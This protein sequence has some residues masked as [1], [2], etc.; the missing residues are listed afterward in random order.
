MNASDNEITFQSDHELW[1]SEI[2]D[3]ILETY[4]RRFWSE[5]TIVSN[6]PKIGDYYLNLT[7]D[8]S[9]NL[10]PS[11]KEDSAWDGEE[12]SNPES[13]EEISE[14]NN[15]KVH[16]DKNAKIET[17]INVESLVKQYKN[18]YLLANMV[19][20]DNSFLTL[21]RYDYLNG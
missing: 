19:S 21:H 2:Q 20:K 9:I 14:K 12:Q 1:V 17:C 13:M 3:E 15:E 4:K 10:W 6:T 5:Q 11:L 7:S 16:S 8:G 18:G